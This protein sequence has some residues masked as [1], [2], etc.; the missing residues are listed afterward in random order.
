MDALNMLI[1]DHRKVAGLFEQAEKTEDEKKKRS[2]FEQ[3]STAL[4][5]HMHI[6]ET[7]LYPTLE[8][9]EELQ[10]ISREAVEEHKQVK[11]L[12]REITNLAD[13]SDKFDAKLTVMKENIEHHVEEE[14]TEMFPK[15]RKTLSTDEL[16]EIGEAL[17]TA[18]ADYQKTAKASGG[19]R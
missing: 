3:I 6:E 7:A 12:L 10:D 14:E 16:E 11:T 13:G 19:R 5:M 18:R 1:E 4:G 8:Q 9:H 2:L 17:I 15:M